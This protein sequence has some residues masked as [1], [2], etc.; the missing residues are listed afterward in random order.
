MS[1][2]KTAEEL[3]LGPAGV[4]ARGGPFLRD[5]VTTNDLL[6]EESELTPAKN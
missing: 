3:L 6:S 2:G 1:K 4:G 5:S